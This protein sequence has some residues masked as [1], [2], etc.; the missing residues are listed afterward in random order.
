MSNYHLDAVRHAL[1][2][3][4]LSGE[5]TEISRIYCVN[6]PGHITLDS[7][8]RAAGLTMKMSKSTGRWIIERPWL[9]MRRAA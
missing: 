9:P 1:K 5:P 7:L 4:Q 8:V 2:S 6:L 3:V